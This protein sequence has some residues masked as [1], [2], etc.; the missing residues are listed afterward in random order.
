MRKRSAG[1]NLVEI[2]IA[3]AIVAVMMALAAPDLR[4]FMRNARISALTNDLMADLQMARTEAVKANRRAWFC[5]SDA[6]SEGHCMGGGWTDKYRAIIVDL[7]DNNDCDVGDL[8]VRHKIADSS[9]GSP[10]A[11]LSGN[12]TF[13][14]T[15]LPS[16][17]L[18]G[19]AQRTFR[20]C[21]TRNGP[22]GV[23]AAP[24]LHRQITIA[25]SGRAQV[26]Q[27]NCQ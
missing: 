27:I 2:M 14:V 17:V 15:F 4:D 6:A 18:A 19:G 22:N 26:D 5:V 7:N 8:T 24:F 23:A 11:T 16:G 13:G 3:M 12:S 21:D 9:A 25:P 10:T 1:F 20:I